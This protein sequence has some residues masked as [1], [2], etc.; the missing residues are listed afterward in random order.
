M[1]TAHRA[2][3]PEALASFCLAA[4]L[5]A[6]GP[7]VVH[8]HLLAAQ[9]WGLPAARLAGGKVIVGTQGPFGGGGKMLAFDKGTGALLW[10]TVL[11]SHPAAIITQSATVHGN[12]VYV[13]VASIEEAMAS[14]DPG[15]PCCSF[16]GSML[17]ST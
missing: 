17:A 8:V 1:R 5:R 11:D 3:C 12:R 2:S 10:S 7:D 6:Y 4:R 15:Y 9:L 14:F 13:G 16:R